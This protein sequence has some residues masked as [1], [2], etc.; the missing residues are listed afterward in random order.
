MLERRLAHKYQ[1]FEVDL[2][3]HTSAVGESLSFDSQGPK[4]R[5]VETTRIAKAQMALAAAAGYPNYPNHHNNNH[6]KNPMKNEGGGGEGVGHK[7]REDL[8]L[9]SI[10]TPGEAARPAPPGTEVRMVRALCITITTVTVE[11]LPLGT[12]LSLPQGEGWVYDDSGHISTRI[13]DAPLWQM[14]VDGGDNNAGGGL[15]GGGSV[16]LASGDNTKVQSA[17]HVEMICPYIAFAPVTLEHDTDNISDDDDDDDDDNNDDGRQTHRSIHSNSSPSKRNS[18][19]NEDDNS[20]FASNPSPRKKGGV[21]GDI[22]DRMDK[23]LSKANVKELRKKT[24]LTTKALAE[25]GFKKGERVTIHP[26]IQPAN[27]SN[28]HHIHHIHHTTMTTMT[29]Y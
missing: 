26:S 3:S 23:Y 25:M 7:G 14:G 20:E 16:T 12:S 10:V 15:E 17:V 11:K 19:N 8:D 4:L 28:N 27:Q 29:I 24:G 9:D 22:L 6:P 2:D 5:T 18:N 21:S 1:P 13:Q